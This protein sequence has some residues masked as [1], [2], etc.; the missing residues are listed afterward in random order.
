MFSCC[1]TAEATTD[2]PC[3]AAAQEISLFP[4]EAEQRPQKLLTPF[5]NGAHQLLQQMLHSAL[6]HSPYFLGQGQVFCLAYFPS[7]YS[8]THRSPTALCEPECF[9][10]DHSSSEL[11]APEARRS[12]ASLGA[13]DKSCEA[14]RLQAT[15][16]EGHQSGRECC[17]WHILYSRQSFGS[18]RFLPWDQF[19][20]QSGHQR[21]ERQRKVKAGCCMSSRAKPC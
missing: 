19:W 18:S 7:L 2:Q 21:A 15:Y 5:A 20:C 8:V 9:R 16:L 3:Q 11:G 1:C 4:G 10:K 6:T 17:W 13:C 12:A 14:V